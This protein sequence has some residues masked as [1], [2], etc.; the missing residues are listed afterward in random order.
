MQRGTARLWKE[1]TRWAIQIEI[2]GV[3]Y[4]ERDY[5]DIASATQAIAQILRMHATRSTDLDEDA[6]GE[7]EEPLDLMLCSQ[8]GAGGF[9]RTC[10]HGCP[11][12]IRTVDGAAYCRACR[13]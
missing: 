6:C 12:P 5:V 11:R 7:C 10:E 1:G 9:L 4:T 13:A 3:P 2:D 8:C